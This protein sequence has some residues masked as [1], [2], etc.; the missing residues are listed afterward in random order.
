MGAVT[1]F[2]INRPGVTKGVRLKIVVDPNPSISEASQVLCQ[3]KSDQKKA[4]QYFNQPL[5]RTFTLFYPL[6]SPI[7]LMTTFM[8][9]L[10]PT[11]HKSVFFFYPFFIPC[12]SFLQFSL[13]WLFYHFIKFVIKEIHRPTMVSLDIF[14]LQ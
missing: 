14:H 12:L 2:Y 3:K 9:S 1:D 6:L 11:R 4:V 10:S 13:C 5:K 8:L 7:M